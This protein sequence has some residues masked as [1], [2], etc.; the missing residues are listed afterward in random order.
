MARKRINLIGLNDDSDRSEL[1]D[2][3]EE[4]LS[5]LGGTPLNPKG[6]EALGGYPLSTEVK[7]LSKIR[8]RKAN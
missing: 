6:A 8:P 4:G 1:S 5:M 7:Y 3:V 2:K